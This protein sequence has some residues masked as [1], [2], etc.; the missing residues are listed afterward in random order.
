MERESGVGRLTQ[1]GRRLRSTNPWV[2][3]AFLATAFIVLVFV[4]HF[5]DT[6]NETVDYRDPD[7]LSVIA[8]LAAS[9]PYFFRRRS[10]LAVL[11][12]SEIGTV[13]LTVGE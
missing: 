11:L 10:P 12:L 7:L 1:F 3:D 8:C 9:V 13:T 2:I 5:G 6:G 4:G